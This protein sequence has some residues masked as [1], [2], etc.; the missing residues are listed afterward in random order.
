LN[1][2][3]THLTSQLELKSYEGSL[4]DNLVEQNDH[5]QLSELVRAME[6]ELEVALQE[7]MMEQLLVVRHSQGW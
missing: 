1:K 2:K 4:F 5:H 3:F 7:A 6:E